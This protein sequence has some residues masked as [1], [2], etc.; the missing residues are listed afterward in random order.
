MEANPAYQI[1][2]FHS[3][4]ADVSKQKPAGNVDYYEDTINDQNIS[5]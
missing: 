5:Y 4:R 3:G 2:S 1:S